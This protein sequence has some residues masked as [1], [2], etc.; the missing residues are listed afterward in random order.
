M[1]GK[2]TIII[3]QTFRT[4]IHHF[5]VNTNV[6]ELFGERGNLRKELFSVDLKIIP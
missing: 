4:R 5:D 1:A 2:D 6:P 3:Y